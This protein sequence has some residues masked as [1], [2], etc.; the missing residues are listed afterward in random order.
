MVPVMRAAFVTALPLAIL[1]T[2]CGYTSTFGF[3]VE[4]GDIAAGRQTFIEYRCHRCHTVAG[5][6]LPE[7]AGAASP[8][9][10]LGGETSQ[11]K[12]YSELVTSIINPNHRISDQY[13]EQLSQPARRALT[14]PMPMDHIETMTV[15]EVIDLVA[16]LDSRYILIDDYRYDFFEDDE[17][18]D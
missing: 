6:A 10:E 14:T 4:Q 2:A 9:F 15:R 17:D 7:I 8:R 11:V 1:L 12:A 5:V 3:P 16:F 18:A 13:R